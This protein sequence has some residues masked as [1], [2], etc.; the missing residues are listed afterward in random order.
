MNQDLEHLRLLSIFYYVFAGL[1]A[2]GGCCPL[3]Y[4]GIFVM[5]P[6]TQ[7]NM[8]RPGDPPEGLF[9]GMAGAMIVLV[10]VVLLLAYLLFRAGRCLAQHRSRTFCMVMAAFTCLSVPLGTVLGVFTFIVLMRPS[11]EQLF[12]QAEAEPFGMPLQ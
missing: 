12:R 7:E 3:L 2:L 4:A 10:L 6:F 8:H 1:T 9:L 11:V 5:I